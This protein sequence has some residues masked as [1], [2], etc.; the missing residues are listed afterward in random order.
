[1]LARVGLGGSFGRRRRLD[2]RGRR[3]SGR[4]GGRGEIGSGDV[5]V[6]VCHSVC[7]RRG[8]T[9]GFVIVVVD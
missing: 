9:V 4:G 5:L 7:V 3:A 1:M 6:L 8:H 2:G